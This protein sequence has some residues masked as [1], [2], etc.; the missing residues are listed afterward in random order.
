MSKKLKCTV[1]FNANIG[2]IAFKLP[3]LALHQFQNLSSGVLDIE[4][5]LH[6][7]AQQNRSFGFQKL[8]PS[9]LSDLT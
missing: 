7:A 6:A 2:L 5:G 1:F 4:E 9:V 3:V 8:Y